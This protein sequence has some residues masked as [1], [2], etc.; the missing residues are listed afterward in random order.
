MVFLKM[1]IVILAGIILVFG[2]TAVWAAMPGKQM[3]VKGAKVEGPRKARE[4]TTAD[5]T[6]GK[7]VRI[8]TEFVKKMEGG[9]LYT[10]GGQYSLSGVKVI[11]LTK[12]RKDAVRAGNM[13]KQ[14][15]EMT[16]LNNQL[17]EVVIR[18]RR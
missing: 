9:V 12:G 1:I 14:T 5:P 10:E 11:D 18:Q 16:F 4:A 17:Q 7:P 3:P 13:P 15:A 2:D 8:V 6:K